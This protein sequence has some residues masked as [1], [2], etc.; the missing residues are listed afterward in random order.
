[1][2]EAKA[3]LI[4]ETEAAL[5]WIEANEMIANPEKFHL[6]FLS[7]NKHD[8]ISHQFIGIRGISLKSETKFTLLGVHIDNR[9]TF[10]SHISNICRKAANQINALKRLSVHMGQNEKMVLMKSFLLSNFNYCPLVCHFCSKTDTDRMEKIQKRA[11][12]MVLHDYKSDYETLLQKTNMSTLQIIRIKTLATEI[13]KTFHSLNPI[14]TYLRNKTMR[15]CGVAPP[16]II[17]ER[18]QLP[19]QIIYRRKENLSESPNHQ[20]YWENILVSRF[21]EQFSRNR[22]NLGHFRKLEKISN[23]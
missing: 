16:P 15:R 21:Y 4:N 13:F 19:Q 23:S 8:L 18:L 22:R 10:H 9:L 1:M 17:F 5:N 6:I 20:K 11:L 14:Y 12:R 7:P 2:D 3:L